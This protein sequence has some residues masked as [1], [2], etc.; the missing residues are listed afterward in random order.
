[1]ALVAARGEVGRVVV[2]DDP[3]RVC[4]EVAEAGFDVRSVPSWVGLSAEVAPDE[5]VWLPADVSLQALRVASA[6]TGAG[7]VLGDGD[8]VLEVGEV[9][10]PDGALVRRDL[11]RAEVDGLSLYPVP[12]LRVPAKESFQ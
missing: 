12:H 4:D 5:Q 9:A 7:A 3:G 2:V 11:V 6:V 8:F 1:S 10:R